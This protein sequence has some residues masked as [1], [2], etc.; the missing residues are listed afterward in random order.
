M[1]HG[2]PHDIMP[3]TILPMDQHGSRDWSELIVKLRWLGLENEAR[4]LARVLSALPPEE[5]GVVAVGPF[6]TD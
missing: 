1:E 6:S 4:H 2:K 5:R 3:A